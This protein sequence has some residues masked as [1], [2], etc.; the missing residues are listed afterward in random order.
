MA[1]AMLT[2][3]DMQM[4]GVDSNAYLTIKAGNNIAADSRIPFVLHA[5][6]KVARKPIIKVESLVSKKRAFICELIFFIILVV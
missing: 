4:F 6:V 2:T 5:S 3:A 1:Y